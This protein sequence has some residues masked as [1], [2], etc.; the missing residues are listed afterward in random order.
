MTANLYIELYMYNVCM[1]V[2]MY[3]CMVKDSEARQS[4]DACSWATANVAQRAKMYRL[5]VDTSCYVSEK[6]QLTFD[7]HKHQ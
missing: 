7:L 4:V 3:T 2:Y 1:Y 6:R 5:L